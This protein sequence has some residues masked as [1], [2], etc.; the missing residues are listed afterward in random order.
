MNN[1]SLDLASLIE[2]YRVTCQTEGKSPRTIEWYTSFLTRFRQFLESRQMHTDPS[3][4]D[5][6]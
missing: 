6:N 5:K 4:I 1:N 3:Q 2:E